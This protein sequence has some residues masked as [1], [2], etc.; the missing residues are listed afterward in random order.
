MRVYGYV[1][2]STEQQNCANQHH[3]IEMFCKKNR[4]KIN[5]WV[6]ETVS[7]RKTLKDRKLGQLLP[8]LDKDCLLITTEI[9]RLGRNMLEVMGILQTCLE[10]DCKI[11]TIKENYRLGSDIQSKV[12]AFTFS[13]ASEIERQLISQRT[14]E[15]LKR[16]KDEGGHLGRPFGFSY[17]KLRK[18]HDK[19]KDLLYEGVS[20]TKIAKQMGCSWTTLNRYITECLDM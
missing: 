20:K 2:V 15:S 19:I 10:Q 14:R 1:R 8:K 11:W 9:S 12:L 16:L 18:K 4:L 7:S 5:A 3:E 17:K 6:E 13:L